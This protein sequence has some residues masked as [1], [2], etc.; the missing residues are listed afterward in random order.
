[1]E[2]HSRKRAQRCNCLVDVDGDSKGP[3]A[4]QCGSFFHLFTMNIRYMIK[5]IRSFQY[6]FSGIIRFLKHEKN[7]QIQLTVAVIAI[8]TGFAL[9]IDSF[10]W[11]AIIACC[12]LVLS[13]EMINTAIEKTCDL[14]T[15]DHHPVI[16]IIKDVAAGAVLVSAVASLIIGIIIFL[17]KILLLFKLYT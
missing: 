6:A 17:P 4:F 14:I 7:G 11:I 1:M 2:N 15:T 5:R 3:P 8:I 16:K 10:E 13:F 9:K 12:A